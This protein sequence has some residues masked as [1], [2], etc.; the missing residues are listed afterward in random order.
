MRT[1]RL[2]E[3]FRRSPGRRA[4]RVAQWVVS[5]GLF[6]PQLRD[7][8]WDLAAA[9]VELEEATAVPARRWCELASR[10]LEDLDTSGVWRTAPVDPLGGL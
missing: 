9:C 5:A 8:A 2:A 10:F 4:I 3:I 7:D 1:P 6:V